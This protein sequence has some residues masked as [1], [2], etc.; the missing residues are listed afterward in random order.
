MLQNT[1]RC[2]IA[3][4][5]S[6][7]FKRYSTNVHESML[8][9]MSVQSPGFLAFLLIR[10]FIDLFPRFLFEQQTLRGTDY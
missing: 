3:K 2:Y 9:E 7:Q 8:I 10:V 1:N 6:T 5:P 4:R